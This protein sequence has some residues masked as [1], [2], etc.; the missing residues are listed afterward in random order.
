MP[1]GTD[2]TVSVLDIMCKDRHA[3]ANEHKRKRDEFAAEARNWALRRDQYRERSKEALAEANALRPERDRINAE[4]KEVKQRRDAAHAEAKELKG[5]DKEA[6][7]AARERGNRIHEELMAIVDKGHAVNDRMTALYQESKV[8]RVL[9]EA[10]HKKFVE[11]RRSADAEH[12]AYLET[13]KSIGSMRKEFTGADD[14]PGAE[15]RC[16]YGEKGRDALAHMNDH[17]APLTDWALGLL[18]DIAPSDILDI[19][20][21]GGMCIGKLHT[22][23]PH[24]RLHGADISEES[25]K[26]TA[27]N[28]RGIWNL[29][30]RNASVSDLPFGEGV[31]QLITAVETYFFWPDLANDIRAAAGHLASGGVML[32]V[33]EMYPKPDLSEHDRDCIRD[34]RMNIVENDAMVSMMGAAGMDVRCETVPENSWVAFVGIKR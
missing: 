16:P 29:D 30:I 34:Y 17:H 26:A 23:Y 10:A 14:D 21:G 19:G 13:R 22:R 1:S 8:D 15:F 25:V 33:S 2:A 27:A 6:F 20:C 9:S 32:I 11:A 28:N 24:A 31:F 12:R 18:P 3:E 4:A 7:E 5:K